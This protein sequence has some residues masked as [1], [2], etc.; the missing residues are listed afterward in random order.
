MNSHLSI[1]VTQCLLFTPKMTFSWQLIKA[2]GLHYVQ[3]HEVLKYSDK[4]EIFCLRT[5]LS[6]NLIY[7]EGAP[8][9]RISLCPSV[10]I[11]CGPGTPGTHVWIFILVYY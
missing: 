11:S 5:K 8:F 1:K 6:N 9:P 3:I 4:G 10:L 2:P 7:C